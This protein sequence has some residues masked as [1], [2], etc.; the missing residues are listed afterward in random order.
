MGSAP[1]NSRHRAPLGVFLGAI[2]VNHIKSRINY[3]IL[4]SIYESLQRTNL[5]KYFRETLIR[6]AAL[7]VVRAVFLY[8]E[9]APKKAA[10]RPPSQ[11]NSSIPLSGRY[12]DRRHNRPGRR[13]TP[14]VIGGV[15]GVLAWHDTTTA[16]ELNAVTDNPIFPEDIDAPALH[17]G[18]F[19]GQHIALASDTLAN[20]VVFLAG[21]TERQIARLTGEGLS[22]A[23][24]HSIST[25]GANQD[26]VS[27]G[28]VAARHAARQL[29]DASSVLAILALSLAQVV[30]HC[31]AQDGVGGSAPLP[32]RFTPRYA[33]CRRR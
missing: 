27:M 8:S 5:L 18:D 4:D 29:D 13:Y 30:D 9:A 17:G 33:N 22:P 3:S 24:P 23:S 6:P 32:G 12:P 10:R 19:M 21:L 28:T 7:G 26:F 20:A 14:Q 31:R 11:V 15:L 16:R 25:N 1:L 2:I